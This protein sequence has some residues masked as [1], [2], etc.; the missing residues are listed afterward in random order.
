MRRAALVISA[1]KFDLE[2]TVFD[3]SSS[4]RR[5]GAGLVEEMGADA[6]PAIVAAWGRGTE[7]LA[8]RRITS[9][10]DGSQYRRLRVQGLLEGLEMARR[11][12]DRECDRIHAR[13]VELYAHE[14]V[15]FCDAD[16]VLGKLHRRAVPVAILT[17]GSGV[18][19]QRKA[20]PLSL[21]ECV[22]AMWTGEALC[23]LK[24]EPTTY[25]SVCEPLDV[26][27]ASGT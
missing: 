13:F 22:T 21:R 27:P 9:E 8:E 2:D 24:P 19:Q 18:R 5:G 15:E 11:I 6:A 10:I 26:N 7:R 20:G 25:L 17:T 12:S 14:W 1:E 16:P 4:A 23:A 3:H